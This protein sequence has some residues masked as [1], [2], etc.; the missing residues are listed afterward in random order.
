MIFTF[1]TPPVGAL[2]SLVAF[3]WMFI[4]M[5]VAVRQS[6]DFTTRRA[7]GTLLTG[8]VIYLVFSLLLGLIFGP[9]ILVFL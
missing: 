8:G 9:D 1:V 2:I 7:I 6:L 4:A 3:V 5:V